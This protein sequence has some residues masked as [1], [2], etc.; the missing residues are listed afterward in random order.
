MI[1]TVVSNVINFVSSQRSGM[2][3]MAGSAIPTPILETGPAC[4]SLQVKF[5][6]FISIVKT[7]KIFIITHISRAQQSTE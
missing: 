4:P 2:S 5:N 6:I 7:H 3:T 1:V